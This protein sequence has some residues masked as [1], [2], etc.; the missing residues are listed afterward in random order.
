[1]WTLFRK[2]IQG[3]FSSLTA[4]VVI[5]VFLL[6]TSSFIWLFRNPL[7][8]ILGGYATL[9]SLF[10]LAPWVFLFL[11]PA[12][13]MRMI[14]EEKRSGTMDL[15][16]TRPV[17]E[18]QIIFAKFLASWALVA[19]SLL[20]TLVW[21]WS[22]SHMASPV[23]NMDMGGTW[24][25]YLGLLFLGGIYA[26]IGIFS[27]SLTGNQIVAFITAVLLS[28]VLFQGFSYLGDSLG[29]GKTALLVSRAGIA[30]HYSSISRGVLDSRDILY[31]AVVITLFLQGARW[32]LQ[33]FHW[34]R[35]NLVELGAILLLVTMVSVLSG[36]KFFRIDFTSEK[37]YS[38]SHSTKEHMENLDGAVFVRIY[39]EGEMPSE[40]INFRNQIEDLMV[41]CRAWAGENLQYEFVNL[42]DEPDEEIRSRMIG[43]LY[44]QGLNVTSIQVSDREGG[45]TAR[46]I[47]P[48]AMVSYGQYTMPV[49][50]LKNNPSLSHEMNLNNSIQ[51][52]EYEFMRAI[53]SLTLDE[54][55]RIAFIEGHGELDSLQTYSLM[56]ELKNFFQVDRGYING[57]VEALKDFKAII[58]ARPTRMFSEADKFALDQYIMS[59]GKVLFFL[60]PVNPFADSLSGGTTVALAN[61]VGLEDL[62][63]KYGVRVNYNIVADMQCSAVPVN[64][65]SSGEQA[66]FSLMPWVY[67]P[68]LM[69]NPS[70]PLTRGL[71]YVK[72]E[73]AS[74]M[75]TIGGPGSG[76]SSTVLLS[77]SNS[78]RS[79][80]VP[81]YISMEEVTVQPDPALY[82]ES[83]LPV[84]V[85]L[86]GVFTSLYKNYPVPSG[87]Y[88]PPPE[89]LAESLPTSIL[90]VTDGDI[91]ANAVSFEQGHYRPEKLGYDRY[92]KQTFGNLD[93]V[94]N[95]IN[96]MCDETG[97]MELRSKEYKLRLLNREITSQKDRLIV[98]KLISTLVPLLLVIL[99]GI[100][101][102]FVR[103]K[104][105]VF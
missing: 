19:L 74:S 2:E 3:F 22:V 64:T 21:F 45:K 36:M 50:L 47:F 94:M 100:I 30:Y 10:V 102:Q 104:K 27:S 54:I 89:V 31:F 29:S 96:Q 101:L 83:G 6:A 24:G 85:L 84:A 53:H 46:I 103:R 18:F 4:Y 5:L 67:H 60:D 87:V 28:F 88:P 34:Q 97:I 39:L 69:G 20:P 41:D 81:L 95:A 49:N 35:R 1:M 77:T 17:S 68:L 66:R 78:S 16:W 99:A 52:L 91:P 32:V 70:H 51:T 56:D 75:D 44:D 8:L 98:W 43:Q 76:V 9:D 72:A 80:E 13:T 37:K 42:Y 65:A 58:V 63:F 40:F 82:K 55:P 25:S 26:A 23:G 57:N 73:F 14:S 38:L 12:I 92:T 59:G 93:F 71:N 105:Y 86:E 90:V 7:N 15:L 79:R 48:G 11:V 62:I 61:Q 33:S